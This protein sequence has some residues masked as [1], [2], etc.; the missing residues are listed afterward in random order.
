M[1]EAFCIVEMRIARLFFRAG[2]LHAG[3]WPDSR[4][5]RRPE[6]SIRV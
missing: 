5:T 3:T 2:R 6:F 1:V 4:I